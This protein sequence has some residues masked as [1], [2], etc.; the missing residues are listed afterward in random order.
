M[1]RG[2]PLRSSRSQKQAD[3]VTLTWCVTLIASYART[4][5]L[6]ITRLRCVFTD[7]GGATVFW[8]RI[9]KRSTEV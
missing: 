1:C 9:P 4:A 7:R 5:E 8:N 6:A 2:Q 3:S